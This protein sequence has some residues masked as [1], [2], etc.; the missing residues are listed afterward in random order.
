[1]AAVLATEPMLANG[2][3]GTT[4]IGKNTKQDF[5]RVYEMLRDE[6]VADPLTAE[7]PQFA[8]DHLKRMLDYNVPGGKLN[9]GLAVADILRVF[10]H[11]EVTEEEVFRANALGWCIEWLQAFFLVADDIMDNSIT[12]RGQACWYRVPGVGMVA[13]NDY[14]LLESCIYR[15]LQ[16]HFS[17]APYYAQLLE[18][19]HETTHQTAHGQLLDIA[20]AP[21]GTVDLSRYTLPTYMRI[22]TYKT[23]FYSFYLPVACGLLVGGVAVP[24]AFALAKN[25]C[26]QMGQYFQIQDDYLDCFGDPAVIGKIGTDIQDNKCSWLVVQAL[27]RAQP[28]QL[29]AL[30]ANYG[31]DDEE[32]VAAVKAL[33]AELGLEAAFREY[34]SESYVRLKALIHDQTLLPAKVFTHLLDK[35]YKRQK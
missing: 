35:I 3:A 31:K 23:A 27:Q 5:V 16:R 11:G 9:R 4:S 25:I 33:Y 24:P 1:M 10:K 22:V 29:A 7:Q 28:P 14:I 8:A 2:A 32:A 20:T 19:F 21:I 17:A 34:E 18:L 30:K 26:I 13:C 15:I 12:R 6:L